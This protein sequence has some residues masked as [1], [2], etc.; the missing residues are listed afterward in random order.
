MLL[1]IFVFLATF[2]FMEFVAWFLHKYVMHGFLWVLHRDHHQ[3]DHLKNYQLNDAF[4]VFFAV[5]SFFSI[6]F[7]SLWQIPLLGAFG[8]GVMAYGFIYFTIHE[9]VI[10]RRWKFFHVRNNWYVEALNVAHKVHHAKLEREEGENFGMLIVPFI[11]YRQA[12]A[13][14]KHNAK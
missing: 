5:P 12:I 4:A 10:H 9:V 13:R 8:Y 2:L 6:L 14:T 1:W 7:D 3:V 11:Y